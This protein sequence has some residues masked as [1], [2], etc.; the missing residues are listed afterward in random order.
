MKAMRHILLPMAIA[1]T[2]IGTSAQNE[3]YLVL[4]DN[5]IVTYKD[6]EIDYITFL[7]ADDAENIIQEIH[8]KNGNVVSKKFSEFKE[9]IF[10]DIITETETGLVDLGL[11]VKWGTHNY[12]AD[13][14]WGYGELVGWGDPSGQH[15]EQYHYSN[16]GA[17]NSNKN[18]V[19]GYY[20]GVTPPDEISGTDLDIAYAKMGTSWRMPTIKEADELTDKCQWQ[21]L[22]YHDIEGVRVQGPSGNAIFLPASGRRNGNSVGTNGSYQPGD[23]GGYWTGTW[24]GT[25]DS[26]NKLKGEMSY[27]LFFGIAQGGF[28]KTGGSYRYAGLAIRPV[29]NKK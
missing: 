10:N 28:Y 24:Y 2:A 23:W 3:C 14:S 4:A 1:M 6:T 22:K 16:L 15:K 7:P 13:K 19:L 8:L 11:S 27:S 29:E 21:W 5:N 12:G 20:G 18:T 26:T 25:S 17:Y 9:M